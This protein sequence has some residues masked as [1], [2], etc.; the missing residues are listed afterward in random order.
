MFYGVFFY[1]SCKPGSFYPH[2]DAVFWIFERNFDKWLLK[3]TRV[4]FEWSI[5]PNCQ[6]PSRVCY[7]NEFTN[8]IEVGI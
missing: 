3:I 6:K 5:F 2:I 8:K 4:I 1:S 7:G